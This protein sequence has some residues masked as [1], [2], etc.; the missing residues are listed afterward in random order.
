MRKWYAGEKL[1]PGKTFAL[2]AMVFF[3]FYTVTT[4]IVFA[5]STVM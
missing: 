3:L 2:L 1:D 5:C 4:F